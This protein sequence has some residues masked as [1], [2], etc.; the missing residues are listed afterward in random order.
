[1]FLFLGITKLWSQ[2]NI[3]P[4][5]PL[6]NNIQWTVGNFSISDKTHISGESPLLQNYLL[7]QIKTLIGINVN[8]D[9]KNPENN[10]ILK[11]DSSYSELNKEAYT[12]SVLKDQITVSSSCEEGIFRGLQ[13]LFQLIPSSNKELRDNKSVKIRCCIISDKPEYQWRGLNLDCC[14]HFMSKDFIRRYIDILAYYKFNKFHWHLTEDQGWRI[15]IKKYPKLTQVGAWRKEADG[16]IYGGFY[17][18]DDIKEIVAY[19]NS[20]FITVIPEIEMP[21]HSVASLTS[22]PENSCTG[23]PFIVANTWGVFK[24]IYCAGRDSTFLFLKDILDEVIQLFP[25]DYIHIGGDEAPKNNWKE[26]PHCQARIK[27]EGLKDEDELQSW[28]IKHMVNYLSSKGKKVIGWDEVLQGGPAPGITIQSWQGFQGAI[29]AAKLGHFTICSPESH[30]YFNNSAENLDLRKVY[31]FNPVPDTLG[32]AERKYVLGSEANL[33]S[34]YLP[35][36]KVDGN[37]FPRLLAL[38]EVLWSDPQ[39]KNYNDFYTRIEKSY[40]DLIALGINYGIESKVFSYQTFFHKDK[41]EFSVNI[42]ILQKGAEI[43]YT[44]DGKEPD[45]ASLLYSEPII[46]TTPTILKLASFYNNHLTGSEKTISVVFHK[47]L[48]SKITLTDL[49]AAHYNGGGVDALTDGL[50]GTNNFHDGLWQG[51]QGVDLEGIIDLGKVTEISKVTPSFLSN[52]ESWIFLPEKVEISLS[53]DN[54]NYQNGVTINNDISL[55]NSEIFIKNYTANFN[56]IKARYIKIKA[57]SI[58]KCPSWHTGAG[59]KAWL[60]IDEIEVE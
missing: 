17:T 14:R 2:T 22:Y 20:R 35:Q 57:A 46:L 53:G 49:Y 10:I 51:Y 23:G 54:I 26:C 48:T 41:N 9:S 45:T 47:A 30:T 43:H 60:F 12:L 25:G 21:G 52:S 4:L 6:P 3:P 50:K 36:E 16:S 5:I 37:L 32:L 42:N 13:T 55:K 40:T 28:F 38:S 56:N 27:A 59:Q 29:E 58:K 33:W 24:D 31:S 1:M 34:E 19:A 15:E 8:T 39:N 18:Q 44:I 11:I 7:S